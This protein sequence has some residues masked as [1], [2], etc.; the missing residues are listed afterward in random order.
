MRG[1]W[2]AGGGWRVADGGGQYRDV[3]LY[4][5]LNLIFN[6]PTERKSYLK[7]AHR[8]E[9]SR[10]LTIMVLTIAALDSAGMVD[11]WIL[12][13]ADLQLRFSSGICSLLPTDCGC[14]CAHL[15]RGWW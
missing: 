10:C 4:H 5:S 15:G 2:V 14:M 1:R 13:T 6:A 7:R 9:I 8:N 12:G 11:N 3:G